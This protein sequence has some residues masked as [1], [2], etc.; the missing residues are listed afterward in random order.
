[1]MSVLKRLFID[2]WLRKLI[3]VALATVIWFI[4]N[5]S[6]TGQQ[7]FTKVPISIINLPDGKTI[8]GLQPNGYLSRLA[9]IQLV[10]HKSIEHVK[11]QDLE[12]V[13]DASALPSSGPL[14]IH[15]EHLR[16]L[17]PDFNISK[18]V[19]KVITKKHLFAPLIPLYTE[20][21]PVYVTTPIGDAPKGYQFIDM[22]PH[23]FDMTVKG[24]EEV[25]KKHKVKGL[26]YTLNLNDI[27][28]KN[29]EKSRVDTE[30]DVISY[31]LPEALKQLTIAD[32]SS[33]PIKFD[34]AETQSMRIDFVRTKTIP[35]HFSI[36]IQIYIP[37]DMCQRYFPKLLLSS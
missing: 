23:K 33:Q 29:L 10:G 17:D 15:K 3:S 25:V 32:I 20:T 26:K 28:V 6:I 30:R 16:S 35:I 21:V 4:V 18:H 22:W 1:M 31:N 37:P 24:P 11:A 9:S 34:D 12:L 8:T 14:V 13:L 2:N 5:Q 27:T 7:T 36:P 19:K